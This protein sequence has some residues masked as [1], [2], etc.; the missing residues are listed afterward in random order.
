[1]S[2]AATATAKPEGASVVIAAGPPAAAAAARPARQAPAARS[3]P[4]FPRRKFRRVADELDATKGM[5]AKDGEIVVTSGDDALR[6]AVGMV[7]A[8]ITGSLL[9]ESLAD[10]ADAEAEAEAAK[11]PRAGRATLFAT[12][13]AAATAIT[14]LEVARRLIPGI[15]GVIDFGTAFR[16]LTFAPTEAG[17][18]EIDASAPVPAV[19]VVMVT[20]DDVTDADKA[21]PGY[22]TPLP[23][24]H[25]EASAS[26]A[27][28]PVVMAGSW[29]EAPRGRTGR[30]RGSGSSR[31]G[32]GGGGGSRARGGAGH[33]SGGRSRGPGGAGG[34]GAGYGGRPRG[35]PS[36]PAYGA[37]HYAA[38]GYGYAAH[39]G[40]HYPA[41]AAAFGMAPAGYHPHPGAAP[42]YGAAH[43]HYRQQAPPPAAFFCR[44]VD[45]ANSANLRDFPLPRRISA[46][47]LS[48]AVCQAFNVP[49]GSVA[50]FGIA[51]GPRLFPIDS[52]KA[53]EAAW[54]TGPPAEAGTV[55]RV[56]VQSTARPAAPPAAG[57]PP[58]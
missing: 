20:A 52:D 15:H 54:A 39:P 43:P 27:A 44:A 9:E 28:V 58:A 41:Q 12:G 56:A 1:M 25:V 7:F 26:M 30:G 35:G 21:H 13:E 3:A 38:P 51:E 34:G 50:L 18:K 10:P 49:V 31:G 40:H 55:L 32:G 22:S 23:D 45:A 17:L 42:Q 53:L 6:L 14:A 2:A 47:D 8:R 11:A 19:R 48:A 4:H 5:V 57:A 33:P 36:H 16:K 46:A 29:T 24:S 37:P